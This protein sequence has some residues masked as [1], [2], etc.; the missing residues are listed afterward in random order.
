MPRK[1][2]TVC[3]AFCIAAWIA[4]GIDVLIAL[5]N[6]RPSGIIAKVLHLAGETHQFGVSSSR[7]AFARLSV[8][9]LITIVL[10]LLWRRFRGSRKDA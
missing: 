10:G 1:L 2:I 6:G 4:F 7:V 9:F 3:F 5:L 8:L